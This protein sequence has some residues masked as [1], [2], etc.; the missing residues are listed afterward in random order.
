MTITLSRRNVIAALGGAAVTWPLMA[1]PQTAQEASRIGVLWHAANEEEEAIYLGAVRRGLSDL[2][3]F[4]G[5]NITLE[6]RFPAEIPERFV[7]LA[8]ELAELNVNVLVAINRLAAL[9]A[10]RATK[11]I[12]IVFVAVPDP[13]GSQLVASLA[14][15]GGNITGLS[16]FAHDLTA[17]RIEFLKAVIPSV[18]NV[19]LLINPND[20]GSS[21][22]YIEEAQNAATKLEL[23]VRPVEIRAPGDLVQAFSKM[24]SDRVDGVAVSQD[25]LFFQTRKEIADLAMTHRLPTIVYSRETLEAGALASYGPSNY[26]IFRRSGYYIDKMLKGTKPEDFPVEQPTK[27]EFIINLKTANLL[28]LQIPFSLLIRADEVIE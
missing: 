11:T 5:K 10:Q 25:G 15:P 22:R 12:P 13:V 28:D 7:R 1:R 18:S 24:Q 8:A 19:A 2:G 14:H 20:K 23:N 17:K 26:E 6:N 16:N 9:A 21:Q 4:E 3:Y 27:F